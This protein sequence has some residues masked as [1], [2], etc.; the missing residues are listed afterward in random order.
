MAS[1]N[2]VIFVASAATAETETNVIDVRTLLQ[3]LVSGDASALRI[4][5]EA[6]LNTI[7]QP[8]QKRRALTK[9]RSL[10]EHVLPSRRPLSRPTSRETCLTLPGS[11]NNALQQQSHA[12]QMLGQQR[13]YGV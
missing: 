11:H 10:R 8:A 9:V 2:G 1:D 7:S 6:H 4:Q 3:V 13:N 5:Q 12:T